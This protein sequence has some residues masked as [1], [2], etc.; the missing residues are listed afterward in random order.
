MHTSNR[1]DS[2]Y[3]QLARA[4]EAHQSLKRTDATIP[5]L[6]RSSHRLDQARLAV[7]EWHGCERPEAR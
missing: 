3:H 6:A 7:W 1:F 4:W 2:L 5:D